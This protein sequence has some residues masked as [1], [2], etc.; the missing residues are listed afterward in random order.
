MTIKNDKVTQMKMRT[1][2]GEKKI[3]EH[4]ELV[5]EFSDTF[6]WLYD[7]LK[8]ISREMMEHRIPLIPGAKPIR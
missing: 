3:K 6:A 7:E 2:L 4:S 1:Q 5:D 8:G